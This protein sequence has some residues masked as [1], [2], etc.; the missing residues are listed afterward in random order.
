MS[1]T[2][3]AAVTALWLGLLTAFAAP[4]DA[5]CAGGRFAFTGAPLTTPGAGGGARGAIVI[6]AGQVAIEDECLA[7]GARM[8]TV[9]ERTKL[10]ARWR[11]CD[12]T[13][14]RRIRLRARID[15]DCT[16]MVGVLR[17]R[18]QGQRR[19]VALVDVGTCAG[20]SD[21]RDDETFCDKPDG[22][23]DGPGR[24]APLPDLCAS[25]IDPV[26]GCDGRSYNN[27]CNAAR[28]GVNVA[29]AG[30]CE[31]AFLLDCRPGTRPIDTNG[32]G[33]PDTCRRP[34]GETCDCYAGL[35]DPFPEPC[36]LDCATCDNYWLCEDG[37]CAAHCGPVPDPVRECQ[38]PLRCRESAECAAGEY[39]ARP[40][41]HCRDT[42]ICHRH[43]APCTEEFA[44]VCGCDQRTYDNPCLAAAAGANIAHRGPCAAP[45][46]TLAGIP[47]PEGEF[48]ELPP[49]TCD[50]ADLGGTCVEIPAACP[51]VWR[52]VCGC[53]GA[54]YSN[55]CE[56]QAALVQKAHDRPCACVTVDCR[57]G[58]VPHDGDGDGCAE[59]CIPAPC[60]TN[61]ECCEGFYC[62][63]PPGP[64][65]DDVCAAAGVCAEQPRGCPRNLDPVCGC[66]GLT[67]PNGCVAAAA[68]VRV[69]HRGACTC[70]PILCPPETDPIDE[71]GDGC[72]DRCL[73][74]CE[75]VCDCYASGIALRNDCPLLCPSCGNFW[76]CEN[77]RCV[78]QCGVIP[79]GNWECPP[80]MPPAYRKTPSTAG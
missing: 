63:L 76:S 22:A 12:G 46:G 28:A 71:D 56:R 60:R 15:A 72:V 5:D 58:F 64:C 17:A 50:T 4:A 34:C 61:G 36:S 16:R 57:R 54:T 59:T 80:A 41:G 13:S 62:A 2:R 69:A 31:C 70:R 37:S 1:R 55:E 42:G 75:S 49:G 7:V 26:C 77:G 11:T 44:P 8:T 40:A 79:P 66:D 38:E 23:C 68:G 78:E 9:G 52:P 43:P 73:T 24:C 65:E 33:C 21:C 18:G 48:C 29:H 14:S 32:D 51:D 45:C 6:A 20:N 19:F 39:C 3:T 25:N 35:P 30:P 27:A 67:Y 53:D 47:C 74:P 10:R